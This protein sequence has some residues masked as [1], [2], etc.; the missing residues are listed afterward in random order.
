MAMRQYT[1]V[2]ENIS[3]WIKILIQ[4]LFKSIGNS[5]K[6]IVDNTSKFPIMHGR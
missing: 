2:R 1:R 6:Q 3:M 4:Y 5:V